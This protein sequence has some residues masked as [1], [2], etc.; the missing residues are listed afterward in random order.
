MASSSPAWKKCSQPRAGL[1]V[2]ARLKLPKLIDRYILRAL[3][4]SRNA[5]HEAE[6]CYDNPRRPSLEV[7]MPPP[8]HHTTLKKALI[9]AGYEHGH[10][11]FIMEVYGLF[12]GTAFASN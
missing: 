9:A 4:D 11:Q 12:A 6:G 10:L 3:V 1:Y 2:R 7:S 8:H 5:R